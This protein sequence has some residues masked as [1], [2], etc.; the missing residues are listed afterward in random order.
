MNQKAD[1]NQALFPDDETLQP[2][3]MRVQVIS[4]DPLVDPARGTRLTQALNWRRIEDLTAGYIADVSACS[5]GLVRYAVVEQVVADEFPVKA[6]GFRYTAKTYMDLISHR[7][8]PHEPDWVDYHR[9]LAQYKLPERAASGE[10]DEVW[11]FGFPSSGF[12][13]SRM[14]GRNAFWCNSPPLEGTGHYPRRFVVMGFSYER[15]VGEMLEDL[16]HRAESVLEKLFERTPPERN[17]WKRFTLYDRIAPGRAEVGTVHFAPNSERDYDWGNRRTVLSRC[18]TWL[19]YP[20][21]AGNPRPVTYA[22]W[23]NGDT[24]LH[25]RWWLSHLPKAPGVTDGISNNWWNYIIRVDH[26]IFN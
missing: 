22:E 7:A 10:I 20:D 26:P 5:G 19:H 21:L 17:P 13:E 11:L 2:I 18:D 6:D 3:D 16:G 15:G 9:I 23:G 14:A 4:F 8:R 25:H 24:R 12:Y 1:R